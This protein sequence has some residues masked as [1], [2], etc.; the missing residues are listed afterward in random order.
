MRIRPHAVCRK[1]VDGAGRELVRLE[2]KP[3]GKIWKVE[4]INQYC[5]Q[6]WVG[7]GEAGEL[8]AK[9]LALL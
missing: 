5:R 7:F 4:W 9:V 2:S 6:I 8:L 3:L 1:L